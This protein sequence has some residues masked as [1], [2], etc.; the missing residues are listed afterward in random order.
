[1]M[2]EFLNVDERYPVSSLVMVAILSFVTIGMLA[3]IDQISSNP[4]LIA[5]FGATA[6]LIYGVP[7]A[8]F[9]R[10]R[11]VLLGHFVSAVIGISVTMMFDMCGILMDLMWVACALAVS[12]SIVV[13][14]ITGC[15]HPPGGATALT[16]VLSGFGTFGYVIR[17]IMLG[18]VLMMIVGQVAKGLRGSI[19]ES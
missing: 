19:P 14:M 2:F 16:C 12:L 18:I 3:A 17:P 9:S 11:N 4:Y 8:K 15:V 5:S 1:M 6:V 10:P 7:N 13:M